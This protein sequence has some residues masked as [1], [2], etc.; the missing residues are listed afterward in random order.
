MTKIYIAFY[1]EEDSGAR[2]NWNTFY[3]PWVAATTRAAAK[4]LAEQKIQESIAEL[5]QDD[6]GVDINTVKLEDLDEEI[7]DEIEY[8]KGS[9]L[10]EIQEG[11][12][13]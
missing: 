7:Q 8:A 6:F 2:E 3:T 5:I 13:L 1:D 10:I 11:D 4:A 12:L 9:Y